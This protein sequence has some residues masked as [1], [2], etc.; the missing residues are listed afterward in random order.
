MAPT[1]VK[2][3]H[4]TS[5]L[6][7]IESNLGRLELLPT[8]GQ[9]SQQQ[10]GQIQ[11]ARPVIWPIINLNV[12]QL[13]FQDRLDAAGLMVLYLQSVRVHKN[14]TRSHQYYGISN[15]SA[16]CCH[17]VCCHHVMPSGT[18]SKKLASH[19]RHNRVRRLLVWCVVSCGKGCYRSGKCCSTGLRPTPHA[20][21]LPS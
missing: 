11:E 6:H 17:H 20:Y 16:L 19:N 1:N 5:L 10:S 12:D 4:Q 21:R 8:H 9:G 15:I 14:V 18:D 7:N 2:T 13:R 3:V